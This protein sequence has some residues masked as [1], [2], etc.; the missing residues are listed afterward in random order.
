MEIRANV[1]LVLDFFATNEIALRGH[2]V[3]YDQLLKYCYPDIFRQRGDELNRIL[4]H[5]ENDGYIE[6]P[7]TGNTNETYYMITIKGQIFQ[8]NGGYVGEKTRDNKI[9]QRLTSLEESRTAREKMIVNLTLIL[10]VGTGI[11]ALIE[12]LKFLSDYVF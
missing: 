4:R 10:A 2:G 8:S 12:V 9:D 1:D 11:A 3:T 7:D 6:K 5:L